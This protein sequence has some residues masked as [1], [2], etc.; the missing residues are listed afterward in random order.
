MPWLATI[1]AIQT[2][3]RTDLPRAQRECLSRRSRDSSPPRLECGSERPK[4]L[5]LQLAALGSG[6]RRHPSPPRLENDSERPKP[7]VLQLAALDSR[8]SRDSSPPRLENGSERPK[9]L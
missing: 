2:L 7:L 1:T 4:P 8:R 5:V 9:P 6:L 3:C